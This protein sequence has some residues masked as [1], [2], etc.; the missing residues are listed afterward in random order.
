MFSVESSAGTAP[1]P[2]LSH[3]QM[4]LQSQL[5][6]PACPLYAHKQVKW[7]IIFSEKMNGSHTSEGKQMFVCVCVCV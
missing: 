1:P 2:N 7:S 5:F 4:S 3:P 6:L